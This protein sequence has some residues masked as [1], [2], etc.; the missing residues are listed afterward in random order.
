MTI[1]CENHRYLVI[2]QYRRGMKRPL[3]EVLH[4]N[5]NPDQQDKFYKL[6][7]INNNEHSSLIITLLRE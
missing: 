2:S 4:K 6:I 5:T 3:T 1:H 7:V